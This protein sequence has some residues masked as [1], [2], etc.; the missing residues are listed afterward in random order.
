MGLYVSITLLG[1]LTVTS[2]EHGP[3][4]EVLKIIWGTTVGLALAHWFAFSL[5]ARLVDPAAGD[6][7]VVKRALIAQVCGAGFVAIVC[8]LAVLVLPE[9]WERAGA[10]FAAAACIGVVTHGK[11]RAYGA[12]HRRAL[13]AGAIALVVGLA[14]AGVKHAISH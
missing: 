10:R 14:V 11:L 13:A 4:H 6:D 5:A 8:T 1:T 12:S 2:S 7:E 9:E 3:Q